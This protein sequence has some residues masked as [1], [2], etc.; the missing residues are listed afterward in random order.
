MLSKV[1][2]ILALGS[3]FLLTAMFPVSGQ[4]LPGPGEADPAVKT[5]NLIDKLGSTGQPTELSSAKSQLVALG[6]AGLPFLHAAVTNDKRIF[7]RVQICFVLAKIADPSS[8]AVLERVARSQFPA[9]NRAAVINL[10]N[11]GGTAVVGSL[12]R[13]RSVTH[14]TNLDILIRNSLNELKNRN[15][16]TN[17]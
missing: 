7:V 3:L 5:Q 9:L 12:E 14:D 16:A 2:M 10:K 4:T 11:I 1:D 8:V 6:K 17:R 15:F 13:I